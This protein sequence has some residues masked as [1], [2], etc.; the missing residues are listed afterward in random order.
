MPDIQFP[1][2]PPV[3]SVFTAAGITYTYDGVR[4]RPTG[5][6]IPTTGIG[7]NSVTSAKIADGTIVDADIAVGAA[8]N[9]A[10]LGASG[11]RNASTFLRGDGQWA[12][13]GGSGSTSA[14]YVVTGL[15]ANSEAAAP[16]NA[17]LIQQALDVAGAAGPGRPQII[18]AG[19][20][21]GAWRVVI[22]EGNYYIDR[23]LLV[24]NAV[25]LWGMSHGSRL[26]LRSG[27]GTNAG[28]KAVVGFAAGAALAGV[29]NIVL[30]GNRL[31]QPSTTHLCHGIDFGRAAGTG[32]V[33]GGY[34][35]ASNVVT[36]M[37][38]G[39][40]FYDDSAA[41]SQNV[42]LMGCRSLGNYYGFRMRHDVQAVGC[43]AAGSL[44][45][46]YQ[47]VQGSGIL[48]SACR[49]VDSGN[50]DYEFMLCTD[51]LAE[52]HARNIGSVAAVMVTGGGY[53]KGD[54]IAEG[55]RVTGEQ[56]ALWVIDDGFGSSPHHIDISMLARPGGAQPWKHALT[57]RRLGEQ[58]RLAVRPGTVTASYYRNLASPGAEVADIEI[59]NSKSGM[60]GMPWAAQVTP[61]PVLGKVIQ[62]GTLTAPM[63]IRNP[64]VSV[65]G[66][67]MEMH[68][69]QNGPGGNALTWDSQYE[70]GA[71]ISTA[72]NA[73]TVLKW[74][75][76]SPTEWIGIG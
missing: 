38:E 67:E 18:G 47:F 59:G 53:I 21:A 14:L 2:D 58:C 3:G 1:I 9:I 65:P 52:G 74:R 46:G 49:S 12:A 66:M 73:R 4:W 32:E 37:C 17:T 71:A 41:V 30:H 64:A 60:Q 75:C 42:L 45:G 57:T 51:V 55:V 63:H 43:L 70:A 13:A 39:G 33:A 35:W 48:L 7:D 69:L 34:L 44:Y 10:K 25:E 29:S 24:P 28:P 22:P 6:T 11:P 23:K 50:V 56:T 54:F 20:V 76:L 31:N 5:E 62:F 72:P 16:S 40:G 36:A 15:V 61:N 27:V 19:I 26:T 68:F 8:I